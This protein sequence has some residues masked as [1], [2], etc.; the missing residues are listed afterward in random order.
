MQK[1]F[2][3]L[4]PHLPLLLLFIALLVMHAPGLFGGKVYGDEDVVAVFFADKCRLRN[5]LTGRESWSFWDPLPFLGMPRLANYQMAWFSPDS[6]YF[7]LLNP[8]AAWRF[9]PFLGDLGLLSCSY[10]FLRPRVSATAAWL[11]AGFYVLTGDCLKATQDHQVKSTMMALLLILGCNQRWLSG[12]RRRWLAVLA[13]ATYWQMSAGAVSHLY[14]QSLTLPLLVILQI[15]EAPSTTRVRRA[16]LAAL[17][18][19]GASLIGLFPWFPLLEWS[20]HGS[21]QLLE[22]ANFTE[23][24]R[25]NLSEAIRV[26]CDEL[27][28]FWPR[29]PIE[30]GGGYSLS[31]GFSIALLVFVVYACRR[32]RRTWPVVTLAVLISLQ[33]LGDRGFF[34]WL[35][36]KAVP[37]TQQIR[38]PHRFFFSGGLLW[39]QVATIGLDLMLLRQRLLAWSLSLWALSLNLWVMGPQ[40]AGA[41]L[42]P[43]AFDGPPL[44]PAGPYR[45]AVNFA[46]NPKP[47]LQWLPYSLTQGRAT[48]IFPNVLCEGNYFRGLLYSQY[49]ARGKELLPGFVY[50][51]TPIPP[52]RP[53]HPLLRSWGLSWVLQPRG[54]Q[55]SWQFLGESPRF[56]TVV[57]ADPAQDA[58]SENQ[59]AAGSDWKPFERACIRGTVPALG[60]TPARILSVYDHPD[61]QVLQTE[62]E[63]CLLLSNDS[64]D[65]GWECLIDGQPAEV[66][67]ANLAL[68]ACWLPPGR[69]EVRWR[70]RLLWPRKALLSVTLGGFLLAGVGLLARKRGSASS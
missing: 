31:A 9:Y 54:E 23:A 46:P 69:H 66:R 27:V 29:G 1:L 30:N 60:K 61:E 3:G 53:E 18:F 24:Y 40:I 25:L 51:F 59:W 10:F 20:A 17:T 48:L 28:A 50:S 12:G 8:L 49:G 11:G 21:R 68:K 19:V 7:G 63:G 33:M 2:S 47:P 38:G 42:E 44:P 43:S 64:W 39:V 55:F 15:I 32:D 16:G 4:R 14:Y 5:L 13:F 52:R 45:M 22:G 58:D 36:H 67:R 35:L 34:L 70:Y 26:F 56:W 57:Q 37:Y 65:P 41:Y 6:L 62:G